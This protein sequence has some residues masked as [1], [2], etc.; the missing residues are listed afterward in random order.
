LLA[1]GAWNLSGAD[2]SSEMIARTVI[3]SATLYCCDAKSIP[4]AS[5]QFD[6]IYMHSVV[7]YFDNDD[8]MREVLAECMRLLKPGGDLCFLDVPLTWYK[9][10]MVGTPTGIRHFLRTNFPALQTLYKKLRGGPAAAPAPAQAVL[11]NVNGVELALPIFNGY[12]A[13]PDSFYA[14]PFS[15]ISIEMQPYVEKPLTYRKFRFN[16][17]MKNLVVVDN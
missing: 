6:L 13:D 14:Y 17:L 12:W 7:Q 3:P 5:A 10:Y 15:Q 8:Y 4:A 11:T 2:V 1:P 9:P 16:V